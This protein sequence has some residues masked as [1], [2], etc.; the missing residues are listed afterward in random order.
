MDFSSHINSFELVILRIVAGNAFHGPQTEKARSP[1]LVQRVLGM[2]N[3]RHVDDQR[4][5]RWV[6]LATDW[7]MLIIWTG[8]CCW[9]TEYI[10]RHSLYWI[11]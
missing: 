4:P 3:V 5:W 1:S 9:Q 10:N 11:W 8:Q 6:E 2:T 7:T